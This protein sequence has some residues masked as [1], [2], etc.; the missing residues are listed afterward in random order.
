MMWRK[1]MLFDDAATAER[2]LAAGHS[3]QA[4]DLGREVRDFD[5]TVWNRNR[6]EIVVAG[7]TAK[8]DQHPDLGDYLRH[9]GGRVLVEAGPVDRVWGIGLAA[10][11]PRVEDPARW[12]GLNLL[13]FALVRARSAPA[14]R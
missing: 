4:K 6:F 1:A 7:N 9:T 3:K 14:S 2:V 8:F 11:D 5:E 10:D 13:G 12:R